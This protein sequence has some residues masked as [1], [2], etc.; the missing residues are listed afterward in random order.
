M[1]TLMT[2]YRGWS[3]VAVVVLVS[4]LSGCGEGPN[5]AHRNIAAKRPESPAE[6]ASATAFV[7]HKPAT[8]IPNVVALD[9]DEARFKSSLA[10]EPADL[11]GADAEAYSRLVENPFVRVLQEPLSTFS[12]DVDTASYANVRRFLTQNQLPPKDA[13]RLEELLNYFPYDWSFA[14]S[15]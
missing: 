8:A 4:G 14:K 1:Q 6:V 9:Y 15:D 3:V 2:A 13:V 7:A 12:I 5:V 10:K 11:T